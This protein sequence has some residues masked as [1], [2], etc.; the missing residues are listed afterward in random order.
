MSREETIR[1]ANEAGLQI[2]HDA[3][4]EAVDK[5]SRLIE[6]ARDKKPRQKSHLAPLVNP[7]NFKFWGII[8][9]DE[10]F[11]ARAGEHIQEWGEE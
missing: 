9:T 6:L 5:L 3:T 1:L 4:S 2:R 7:C 11:A 8:E 10:E